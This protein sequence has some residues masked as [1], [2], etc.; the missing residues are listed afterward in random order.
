MNYR[1]KVGQFG[2]N[3]AKDYLIR[4]GYKILGMNTQISY[5]E[6]DII[7]SCG[8]L[9]VF[10]EVKTRVFLGW[11]GAEEAI[12]DQ[13]IANLAQALDLYIYEKKLDENFVRLD[14]IA[15][16]IDK[17]KKMANIK[18]YKDII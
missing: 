8:K 1:Q 5:K 12:D 16:E 17:N 4:H 6:V 7:A 2:E 14:F 15:I 3:L 18:H 11:G 10:V 9:I 13:K